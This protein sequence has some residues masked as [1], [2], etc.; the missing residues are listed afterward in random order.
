MV[1]TKSRNIKKT[2]SLCLLSFFALFSK[3]QTPNWSEDI[4]LILYDNCTVCHNDFGI[5]PFSLVTY[6]DA[7]QNTPFVLSEINSGYMPPWPP[8]TNY[9]RFSHERVLTQEEID[10]I[11]AWVNTNMPEGDT[12][13]A[14]PIPTYNTG[15]ILGTPD[16]QLTIPVYTSKANGFDD[17]VCISLP[18]GI[19][20]DKIIR[21]IEVVPGN[22]KIVHHALVYLD[23]T[24]SF[25]TDTSGFCG[26]PSFA[27]LLGGYVP[28]AT[29]IIFPDDG[30]GFRTGVSLPAGSNIVLAMHYPDGSAGQLDATSVNFFFYPTGTSNFREVY[31]EPVLQDWSFCI[32]PDTIQTIYDQF[33][34]S[35]SLGQDVSVIS[36]MPHMHLLGKSI[37]AYAVTNANDTIPF[38]NISNWD[39]DWQGFYFFKN[40]VKLPAG[41]VIYGYGEYDNT[42]NNP[43]NPNTPP[44]TVC[45]GD[46]TSDEMFIIYFHYL[47][48]Q[49]GD[50][51][52]NLD[53]LLTNFTVDIP[54][55]NLD[56]DKA[57][58]SF[59]N[60]FCENSKLTY[61]ISKSGHV[62][63]TILDRTGRI[64]RTLVNKHQAKGNY[65]QS[66]DGKDDF[67]KAGA[68][69]Y[70]YRLES[71]GLAKTNKL[72]Y[73]K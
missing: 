23:T 24:A 12:S 44:I 9:S 57:L 37:G 5:A 14:P 19:L 7:Y 49:Q 52:I 47:M 38:I 10:A 68:G 55:N 40:A 22:K 15:G 60:P 67:G 8:D 43:F 65:S 54:E 1:A 13:L 33:P 46:A 39:F 11:V 6:Q 41:S 35:G 51:L 53:S 59:P 3:G 50:E 45:A 31:A 29:P 70:F 42:S 2:I 36:T 30:M 61:S 18:A 69:L 16:L 17:Y 63:L 26:G 27:R 4:A 32:D 20:T 71:N 73:L 21:A 25:Q 64:I 72:I 48:Y 28:G 62:K 34:P 66:W 58:K 56:M